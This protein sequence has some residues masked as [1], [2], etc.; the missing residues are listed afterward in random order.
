MTALIAFARFIPL[1]VS[2]YY[3]EGWRFSA[4]RSV[5]CATSDRELAGGMTAPR[6]TPCTRS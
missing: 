4:A 3:G 5:Q 6:C 2:G 1:P